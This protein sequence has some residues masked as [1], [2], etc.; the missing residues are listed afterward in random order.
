MSSLDTHIIIPNHLPADA[1][2]IYS[3]AETLL[4]KATLFKEQGN[5]KSYHR[6]VKAAVGCFYEGK[7]PPKLHRTRQPSE[8]N[9][10]ILEL[11]ESGWQDITLLSE[12]SGLPQ[13]RVHMVLTYLRRKGVNI[14]TKAVKR[15]RILKD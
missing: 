6:L 11:L 5:M 2:D 14:Q 7:Q 3:A 15:Y 9:A 8:T 10:K 4:Q 13:N 12:A 1:N